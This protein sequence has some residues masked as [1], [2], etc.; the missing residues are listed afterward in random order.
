[1]TRVDERCYTDAYLRM[2]ANTDPHSPGR[3]RANI[4]LANF[5][6]FAATFGVPEGSP[7]ALPDAERARI[8]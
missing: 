4:P 6:P 1:M 8:W 2:M 3:Y 5:P 7:M